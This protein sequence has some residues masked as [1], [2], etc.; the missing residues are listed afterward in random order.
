[1]NI[2]WNND[3]LVKYLGGGLPLWRG[4]ARGCD[5]YSQESLRC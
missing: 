4:R 1:M 2:Q 5:G 3:H